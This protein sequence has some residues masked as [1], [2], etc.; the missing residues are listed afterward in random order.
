MQNQIAQNAY[1]LA[2]ITVQPREIER[3]Y[4]LTQISLKHRN[5]FCRALNSC[6]ERDL[7]SIMI[8]KGFHESA[9]FKKKW[10]C[11]FRRG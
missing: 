6:I 1:L 2:T 4:Y 9:R 3:E 7:Q 8:K 5:A 10:L 11:H